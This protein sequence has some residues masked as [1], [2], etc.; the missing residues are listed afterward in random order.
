MGPFQKGG[1]EE[2][3]NHVKQITGNRVAL[4]CEHKI[5]CCGLCSGCKTLRI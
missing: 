2:K 3:K 1:G 4:E 5:G